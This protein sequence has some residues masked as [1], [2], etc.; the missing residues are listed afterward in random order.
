[1]TAIVKPVPIPPVEIPYPESEPTMLIGRDPGSLEPVYRLALVW[2][3]RPL[4]MNK[5][6]TMHVQSWSRE[7]AKWREAFR[8]MSEGSPPFKWCDITVIHEHATRTL[9][10]GVGCAP[11]YKAA[12]DGCVDFTDD[13]DVFH[14]R[15]L[16]DDASPYVQD[17]IFKPPIYTLRDAL[18]LVFVGPL[19]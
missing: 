19:R 12:L 16:H 18:T 9:S 1:M 3:E 17:Q 6:R 10:D 7:V 8:E 15:I 14:P 11:T 5:F 4:L 2:P 13:D